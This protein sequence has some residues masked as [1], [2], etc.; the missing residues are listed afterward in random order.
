MHQLFEQLRDLTPAEVDILEKEYQDILQSPEQKQELLRMLEVKMSKLTPENDYKFRN[1]YFRWYTNLLWQRFVTLPVNEIMEIALPRMVPMALLLDFNVWQDIILFLSLRIFGSE[2]TENAFIKMQDC[3]FNSGA[4]IGIWKEENVYLSDI[5]KEI[6]ILNSN[7]KEE[8]LRWA[9]LLSRLKQ[10]LFSR[11]GLLAE[12]YIRADK[13]EVVNRLAD[14]ITFFIGVEKDKILYI[15][16]GYVNPDRYVGEVSRR[17]SVLEA[18]IS[19][20]TKLPNSSSPITLVNTAQADNKKQNDRNISSTFLSS[21]T[22]QSQNRPSNEQIKQMVEAMFP[23]QN[24][25]NQESFEK[26]VATLNTLSD[27]YKDESI[28]DL[29]FY[30]EKEGKFQWNEKLVNDRM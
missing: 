18:P 7:K 3:V 28:K 29:Y 15:V 1:T 2:D 8:S 30:N 10:V 25:N 9:E 4:I 12:K 27:Q 24:Q 19:S 13:D 21:V 26:I 17:S 16:E 11:S 5:V 23:V 6:K 14:L 22:D 20:I